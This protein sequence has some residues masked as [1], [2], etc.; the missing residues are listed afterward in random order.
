[1][2]PAEVRDRIYDYAF[3]DSIVS[4]DGVTDPA[5]RFLQMCDEHWLQPRPNRMKH[6]GTNP[7]FFLEVPYQNKC[8]KHSHQNIPVHL[9]Q[10][11]RQIY[12]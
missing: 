3:G 4:I 1:M 5:C 10:V 9:L 11:C 2:L 12:H 6:R 8:D 7:S